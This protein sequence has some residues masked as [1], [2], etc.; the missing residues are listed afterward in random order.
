MSFGENQDVSV[1]Q[2]RQQPAPA[3]NSRLQPAPADVSNQQV[4]IRDVHLNSPNA[5]RR[6]E[7]TLRERDAG[8]IFDAVSV[9]DLPQ[10][11]AY[12]MEG[13]VS[14]L[15]HQRRYANF[16]KEVCLDNML[17]FEEIAVAEESIAIIRKDLRA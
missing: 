3:G 9:R 7:G 8:A 14:V 12:E 13:G 4:T 10:L 11:E 6:R 1:D 5:E 15:K 17:L 2:I 16:F